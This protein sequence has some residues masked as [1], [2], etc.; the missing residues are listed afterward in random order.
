V[1]D[2]DRPVV[3]APELNQARRRVFVDCGLR[4]DGFLRRRHDRKSRH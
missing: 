2:L 3:H 1:L 4:L